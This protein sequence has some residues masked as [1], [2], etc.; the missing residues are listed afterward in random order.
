MMKELFE[1]KYIDS[2][3]VILRHNERGVLEGEIEGTAY[4]HL[5]LTRAFPLSMADG[6]LAI[7]AHTGEDVDEVGMIRTLESLDKASRQ[8]AERE[9]GL[10][11][12]VPIITR[13]VQIRQEAAF[14]RLNVETDRGP[15]EIIMRNIHEHVRNIGKRRLLITDTEGRRFEFHDT[16]RLDAHSKNLIRRYL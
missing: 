13:I 8:A 7:L 6:Y 14:W 16:A 10:H 12:V 4:P 5:S 2:A 3:N 11:Y 15:A 9:L 1:A